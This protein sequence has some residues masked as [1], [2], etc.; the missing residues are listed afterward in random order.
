MAANELGKD[1]VIRDLGL[2]LNFF[3][4]TLRIFLRN[5][6]ID[7]GTPKETLKESFRMGWLDDEEL[8]LNMLED[9]NK[10]S[11][12]YNRETSEVIF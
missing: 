7:I 9:R 10:T 12:L 11:H 1:G 8:F 4:K 3:R 5:S 2:P 6:G